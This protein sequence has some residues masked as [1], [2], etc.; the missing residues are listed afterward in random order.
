MRSSCL[1][2]ATRAFTCLG[3]TVLL[4]LSHFPLYI[5]SPLRTAALGGRTATVAEIT[6]SF[7]NGLIQEIIDCAGLDEQTFRRKDV[8]D[9]AVYGYSDQVMPLLDR[10]GSPIS[11]PE[12]ADAPLGLH[13]LF[14]YSY[15]PVKGQLEKSAV[16]VPYWF[17]PFV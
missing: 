4:R 14:Q 11:L 13:S 2:C 3:I 16:R 5:L 7:A 15:N 12:L 9:I 1:S 8:C 10:T 6:T 17:R